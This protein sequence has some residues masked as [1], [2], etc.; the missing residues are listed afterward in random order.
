[1]PEGSLLV[2]YTDGLIEHVGNRDF[3]LGLNQLRRVLAHRGRTPEQTCRV[4]DALLS[5]DPADDIAVLVARTRALD[6]GQV[7]TWDVPAEPAVVS[8]IRA[9]VIARLT[10]WGLEELVFTTELT[11]SEL[12]TNAIRY[13]GEPITL[14][15]LRD[16]TLICEVSDGSSTSPHLRRARTTDEGGRG[17]YLVAQLV[18]RWGTRYGAHGKVIWTEQPLTLL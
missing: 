4:L 12:V 1:V 18:Q 8:R 13:G 9:E 14:R 6:A 3:E 15:L 10:Q 5:A 11:V 2:L 16:R 7:A 17:L